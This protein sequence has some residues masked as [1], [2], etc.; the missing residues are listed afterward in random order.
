MR[1]CFGEDHYTPPN[2]AEDNDGV[3]RTRE[4]AAGEGQAH[5]L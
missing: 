4:K 2:M 3:E 5:P 1:G